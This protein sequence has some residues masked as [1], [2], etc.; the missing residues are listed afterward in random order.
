MLRSVAAQAA[1][2]MV[3][4]RGRLCAIGGGR[5]KG[6]V[7]VDPRSQRL[8]DLVYAA[9]LGESSWQAFLDELRTLLP[10]G[11]A[12]L[13]YH[14]PRTAAGALQLTA[15]IEPSL[16]AQYEAYYSRINPW[17]KSAATRQIGRV[18]A[19]DAMLPRS[20][21]IQTEYYNDYLRPRD[22]HTGIGVTLLREESCN[23]LLSVMC[24]DAE[25]TRILEA[26]DC[27]QAI[28]PHMKRAFDF[29]RR[30]ACSGFAVLSGSGLGA[31]RAGILHLGQRFK[32]RQAN[33]IARQ[34]GEASQSFRIDSSGRFRC[35]DSRVVDFI[36]AALSAWPGAHNGPPVQTFLVR[37][38]DSELP[39]RMTVLAPRMETETAFFRGPECILLVEDPQ[40][41]L[42]PAVEEFG[43]FFYRLT[44]A[45]RR[46]VLGLASG[47]TIEQI[48]AG[49]GNSA[50]TTRGQLKQVF[51]KTGLRR[52]ADLVRLVCGLAASP[53]A[54]LYST[55]L[56][57]QGG[58][59]QAPR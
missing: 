14:D 35:C 42:A 1:G 29:Y 5:V 37:R 13:F 30:D 41:E 19:A 26:A 44:A 15:E 59:A 57:S 11:K 39:L 22:V 2:L 23:F 27:V 17:M 38:H 34:L 46:V 56:V 4:V 24:A 55:P 32:V 12:V 45:E 52:Q 36:E 31:I 8:I 20:E 6:A 3:Q 9:L 18:V 16:S 43:A 25:E 40:L 48:S 51:A 10:N 33:A 50:G 7:Q 47:L 21:L 58:R 54:G 53:L 28:V 49:A